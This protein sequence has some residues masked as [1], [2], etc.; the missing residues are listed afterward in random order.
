M[1]ERIIGCGLSR[2]KRSFLAKSRS[3]SDNMGQLCIALGTLN[4][5]RC[6]NIYKIKYE[7]KFHT[8]GPIAIRN[9]NSKLHFI[10]IPMLPKKTSAGHELI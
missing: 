9:K 8:V 7:T 3:L 5:D 6:S 10:R 4:I 1:R 2:S